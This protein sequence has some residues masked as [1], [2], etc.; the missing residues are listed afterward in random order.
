M[1]DYSVTIK[2]IHIS[3]Q[4]LNLVAR[5]Y[6]GKNLDDALQVASFQEKKAAKVMKKGIQSLIGNLENNHSEDYTEYKLVGVEVN[7]AFV[8]R[9]VMYRAK[10]RADM[11]KKRF[12]SI[13]LTASV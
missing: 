1:K 3:P 5:S 6:V 11:I 9:R 4:K 12:S 2:N 8:L 7:K 10:G 13:K